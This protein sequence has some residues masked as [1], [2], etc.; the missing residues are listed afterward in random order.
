MDVHELKTGRMG[1]AGVV[2]GETRSHGPEL[3]SSA[4]G[5]NLLPVQPTNVANAITAASTMA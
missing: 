4:L 5:P 2:V 1:K 3:P